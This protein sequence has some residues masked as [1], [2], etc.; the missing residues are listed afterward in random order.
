MSPIKKIKVN[1]LD[2]SISIESNKDDYFCLTD[3]IKDKEGGL[4]VAMQIIVPF[5]FSLRSVSSIF[6]EIRFLFISIKVPSMSKKTILIA[7]I[8]SPLKFIEKTKRELGH[9]GRITP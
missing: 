1:N 9:D 4:P 7:L 3:I 6:S 2:I 5:S 8:E